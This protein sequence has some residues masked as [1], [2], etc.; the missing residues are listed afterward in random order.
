MAV[1]DPGDRRVVVVDFEP[2][3]QRDCVLVGANARLVTRQGNDELGD[4]AATP[5]QRD[6]G[7]ALLADHVEGD[8]LDQRSQ[9]LF[10]VAIS[11]RR[12]G[13]NAPP[14]CLIRNDR[15]GGSSSSPVEAITCDSISATSVSASLS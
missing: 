7:A 9:Q 1:E 15:R 8:F 10:A 6:C 5:A 4:R 12:R 13:P 2:P 11:S 3:E 14:R